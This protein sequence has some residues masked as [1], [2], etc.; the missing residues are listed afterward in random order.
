M[1][2]YI[3]ERLLAAA[4]KYYGLKEVP[5][6]QSNAELLD[7]IKSVISWADDDSTIS[8]C[9]IFIT[10]LFNEL[11]LNHLV[12]SRSYGARQWLNLERESVWAIGQEKYL[13]SELARPGD[14]V[15]FWRGSIDDWR[16]HVA[17]YIN[18][19][20]GDR[21]RVLGGNQDNAVNIRAYNKERILKIIRL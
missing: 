4:M 15:V 18:E 1:P 9:G 3:G 20:D 13:I 21:I 11:G 8:W 7:I 5:G 17:L 12:P 10:Y 19:Y 2:D 6:D 14:I 16:G